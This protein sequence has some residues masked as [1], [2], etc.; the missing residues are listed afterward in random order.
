MS[1][2][3]SRP[4]PSRGRGSTRGSRGG[5]RRTG[6]RDRLGNG[7]ARDTSQNDDLE[8]GEIGE[9]KRKYPKELS[10]LKEM[11]PDWSDVDLLFALEE[12]DG[13]VFRTVEHISAGMANNSL[14]TYTYTYPYNNKLT[15]CIGNAAQF[16]DVKKKTKDRS[17]SKA[18]DSTPTESSSRPS[19]ART[20]GVD[21]ARG[22]SRGD[23]SRASR[24]TR[25]G[26]PTGESRNAGAAG[27]V[28][29]TESIA[30]DANDGLDGSA[31]TTTKSAAAPTTT[32]PPAQTGPPKKTWASMFA[33]QPKPAPIV[34]PK[35]A[36][37]PPPVPDTGAVPSSDISS[38]YVEVTHSD[39]DETA[40]PPSHDDLPPPPGLSNGPVAPG[41]VVDDS[42]VDLPPSKDKLTEDNVEHLPDS[43]HPAP[44]GTAASTVE[45]SRGPD[46][47]SVSI[48]AQAAQQAPIGRSALGGYAT[49]AFKATAPQGRSVSFQRRLM[50]QQEAVVLPGNHAVDRAAMQFGSLGLNGEPN[51]QDVDEER[52]DAETRPQPPQHSPTAQP[53]ASLPQAPRSEPATQDSLSGPKPAPGLT[54]VP[55][56]EGF[57]QS[58][59]QVPSGPQS[60]GQH[61]QS[62]QGYNQFGRYGS[63]IPGDSTATQKTYINDPFGQQTAAQTTSESFPSHS[64]TAGQSQAQPQ[65]GG[66]TST[67]NE[68]ASYYGAD[69]RGTYNYYGGAFGQQNVA[70]QEGASTQRNG[71]AFTSGSSE[72]AF[73]GS[74]SQVSCSGITQDIFN[75]RLTNMFVLQQQQQQQ[76]PQQPQQQQSRFSENQHSG[77][78]TPNPTAPG[79]H[80]SQQHMHQQPHGQGQHAG[81]YGGHPYYNAPYYQAYMNQYGYGQQGFSGQFGKGGVYG[82]THHGYNVPQT[83]YDQHSSSPAVSGGFGADSSLRSGLTSEYSRSGSTQPSQTQ[84]HSTAGGFGNMDVFGRSPGSFPSQA[85]QFGQQASGQQGSTDESLKPLVDKASGPSPSSIGQPGRPSSTTNQSHQSGLPPPQSQQGF[86]GYPSQFSQQGSQYGGLGNLGAH[87]AGGQNHQGQGYGGYGAGFSNYNTQSYGRGWGGNYTH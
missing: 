70:G 4:L 86:G 38:G 77:H 20:G 8:Q 66:L 73:P 54:Q 6:G 24:P 85:Q 84:Q 18:K 56:K 40:Q 52:E 42:H 3:A 31:P 65:L 43:S 15:T 72:N 82:P 7:D 30:W 60:V 78:N 23:R 37:E 25:A 63:S 79:Q 9:M 16:S 39:I 21:S 36:V 50:E 22:R 80:S 59:T 55:Q 71:G 68:Y 67:S 75:V 14:Y 47:T 28:P 45:S 5:F 69:Q 57:P 48:V 32:S 35:P 10:S 46:S 81:F 29:T 51:S 61:P 44:T 34:K 62:G 53:R 41:I 87:Q 49:T 27:S 12:T 74:Q 2:T 26:A 17:R 76:Q 19:R 11:F 33:P 58:S 64:Q 13:D 1:E 83:S